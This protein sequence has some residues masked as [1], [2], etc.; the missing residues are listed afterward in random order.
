MVPTVATENHE[1]IARRR[2]AVPRGR[3]SGSEDVT[4]L[5]RLHSPFFI[6]ELVIAN[7]L[8]EVARAKR[9]LDHPLFSQHV[10]T[11]IYDAS[12]WPD[13][14][15]GHDTFTEYG[16]RLAT[17]SRRR[18][19]RDEQVVRQQANEFRM[20]YE[21]G[22]RELHH[23]D[24]PDL[25]TTRV[26]LSTLVGQQSTR[27]LGSRLQDQM[28]VYR[29]QRLDVF[30]SHL[31]Y[32]SCF[33]CQRK[34]MEAGTALS[35]T[36]RAFTEMPKL[37]CLIF[38][39]SRGLGK[40]GESH[41]DLCTRLFHN[42]IEPHTLD[43]GQWSILSTVLQVLAESGRYLKHL[44]IGDNLFGPD[45]SNCDNSVKRIAGLP[46]ALVRETL[47]QNGFSIDY[48][49][50]ATK[51][52]TLSLPVLFASYQSDDMDECRNLDV[53]ALRHILQIIAPKVVDLTLL[54]SCTKSWRQCNMLDALYRVR[55]VQPFQD[56][57]R[58]IESPNLKTLHIDG[59]PF[60]ASDMAHFRTNN[61]PT[62]RYLH[63]TNCIVDCAAP[64]YT[65]FTNYA[66]PFVRLHGLEISSLYPN[67]STFAPPEDMDEL[68]AQINE[69]EDENE[70]QGYE[71][72]VS[73]M[74]G[75]EAEVGT[76]DDERRVEEL[77]MGGRENEIDR[78]AKRRTSRVKGVEGKWWEVQHYSKQDSEVSLAPDFG[79]RP[80]S[81]AKSPTTICDFPPQLLSRIF[82]ILGKD[83][84]SHISACRLVSKASG[85]HAL[86]S[87]YLITEIV[88][89]HRLC[90]LAKAQEMLDY[91][92]FRQHVTNVVYDASSINAHHPSDEGVRT[93]ELPDDYAEQYE[94]TISRAARDRPSLRDS[95]AVRQRTPELEM[96]RIADPQPVLAM[97]VL[98]AY[99]SVGMGYKL[100]R[101]QAEL[102]EQDNHED[103]SMAARFCFRASE[104]EGAKRASA[105]RSLAEYKR[106]SFPEWRI[107]RH[108]L[109]MKL[110]RGI[111]KEAPK[112]ANLVFTDFR[113][114]ARNGES[115]DGLCSRLFGLSLEPARL[116]ARCLVTD[117][118][119]ELSAA[120]QAAH[121]T[122]A[123]LKC[124][125]IGDNIF[126][127][128]GFGLDVDGLRR[129]PGCVPAYLLDVVPGWL[130]LAHGLQQR[131]L[132]IAFHA[133]SGVDSDEI[134]LSRI[135]AGLAYGRRLFDNLITLTLDII[136]PFMG[137]WQP[138]NRTAVRNMG[139]ILEMLQTSTKRLRTL[140]LKWAIFRLND[141]AAVGSASASTLRYLHLLHCTIKCD[142]T[143]PSEVFIGPLP[144]STLE[145]VEFAHLQLVDTLP[146]KEDDQD[147][148]SS[149]P[150]LINANSGRLDDETFGHFDP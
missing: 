103:A 102:V 64:D 145:S 104:F 130:D 9:I 149:P 48:R 25:E 41:G 2:E 69:T 6:T 36:R 139:T 33:E 13:G 31:G 89:A 18:P 142:P 100:T 86:S 73:F 23:V 119:L 110:L 127:P 147:E 34:L 133:K 99:R 148:S 70:R 109:V 116:D 88:L 20:L 87:P 24:P 66:A 3:R 42:I 21:L 58:D 125:S 7:R 84:Q 114:L 126:E 51:L 57:L 11:L 52:Q 10:T 15:D 95:E 67:D 79:C 43:G 40:N 97:P 59:W 108:G 72:V 61:V 113:G 75:T 146:E 50:L 46:I 112:V 62:L 35:I 144:Y 83:Y 129:R 65:D 74:H 124:V 30:G 137:F 44:S 121:D 55:P 26:G 96:W 60:S 141:I 136:T 16:D 98:D 91:P 94:A 150:H 115:Y 63:L 45:S 80:V 143:R 29:D 106:L 8:T 28:V 123:R 68:Y 131:Y 37:D 12:L 101:E 27:E 128:I 1:A 105:S 132:P 90:E 5:D 71:T 38:T 138:A 134:D 53:P 117:G 78:R 107:E 111:L 56:I 120:L 14:Q 122:R 47:D 19:L 77:L 49:R 17:A 54:L 85:F 32:L 82:Q 118:W 22:L 76:A 81:S 92:Y 4:G 93:W 135:D 140:T 39:D